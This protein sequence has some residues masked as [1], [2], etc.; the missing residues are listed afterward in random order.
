M[1]GT[2]NYGTV[3]KMRYTPTKQLMAMKVS[4]IMSKE[5]HEGFV[6]VKKLA[7]DLLCLTVILEATIYVVYSFVYLENCIA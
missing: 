2:G 6:I 1:L 5:E 3:S 4:D 7:A